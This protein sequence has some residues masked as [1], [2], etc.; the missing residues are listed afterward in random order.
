MSGL[1]DTLPT[2][3]ANPD[4]LPRFET[5]QW[6]LVL[7]AA[8]RSSSAG[9][10][11]LAELCQRYW[12]PLYAF[13]RSRGHDVHQ[14]Q[15]LTQGF[16]QR[17]IEKNYMGDADRSK[18]RFRT[19]LMTSLTNFLANEHDHRT[20]LKRG[21]GQRLLS[22]D[23]DEAE[24]RIAIADEAVQSAE[25]KFERQWAIALLDRVLGQLEREHAESGQLEKF[26]A[27]KSCLTTSDNESS[28]TIARRLKI[29]PA[30]TRVAIHR[31]RTRYRNM[32]RIEIAATVDDPNE[33]DAEIGLLFS[34]FSR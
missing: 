32:L 30:A 17:V 15:D 13:V 4:A 6:S 26:Q 22:L 5:T 7:Q 31:L 14:A 16:F 18:G 12:F 3:L 24:Q 10:D 8:Q 34:A 23:I 28:E 2:P 21:G 19:F 33:V 9:Q 27:L 11:A 25:S 1:D 29:T 20:A